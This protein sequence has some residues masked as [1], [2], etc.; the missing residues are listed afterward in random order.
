M[1]LAL[2]VASI[3]LLSSGLMAAQA[4]QAAISNGVIQAKLFLPDPEQG[5]YRGTRF[6][7]SG[8]ISSLQYKGHEYFG[9]WFENYDPK[10]HDAITGPVEEYLTNEAG[11]GYDEAKTGGTFVRIGVG[12]VRKPE[13]KAYRR[14]E[15][16]EIVDTGKWGVKKGVDWIEFTHELKDSSGYA[17]VYTKKVRLVQSRPQLV[18]EHALR[19]T[20]KRRIETR[21]YNHNFFVIDQQPTGPDFVVKFPFDV[22][23]KEEM[24]GM[25]KVGGRVLEYLSELEKGQSVFTDLE[26]FGTDSGDY[27]LRIENRKVG[28][29]VRITGDQPLVK[30]YFWSIRR[31]LCPEP[32]IQLKIAPGQTAKWKIGYEFYTTPSTSA[33]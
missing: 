15:T 20:G 32:Y 31:T 2:L 28:A 23:A 7:W 3:L 18:L 4:P 1:R 17:Y 6:D 25:A 19:N 27:D 30:L 29:A 26:G 14:F 16:Y 24:K 22:R 10:I 8:V 13:E 21:Q 5:Y 12:V 11:L 9:Q 33:H